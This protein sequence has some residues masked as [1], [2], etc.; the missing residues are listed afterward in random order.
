MRE[1]ML[2]AGYFKEVEEE[3]SRKRM[4]ELEAIE[5]E[6]QAELSHLRNQQREQERK[7]LFTFAAFA[8]IVLLLVI[9]FAIFT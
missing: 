4:A 9:L 8:A 1:Q 5:E 7:M 3:A 2:S 6:R